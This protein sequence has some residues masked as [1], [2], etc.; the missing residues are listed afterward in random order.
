MLFPSIFSFIRPRHGAGICAGPQ[1]FDPFHLIQVYSDRFAEVFGQ[2]LDRMRSA[3]KVARVQFGASATVPRT[4]PPRIPPRSQGK[5]VTLPC[6]K[7]VTGKLV[8]L[9]CAQRAR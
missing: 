8:T 4:V 2:L 1:S 6:G 9:P 7:L 3:C 5:L